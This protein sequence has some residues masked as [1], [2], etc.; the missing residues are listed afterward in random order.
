MTPRDAALGYLAA[1]LSVV[2][3]RAR[4]KRPLLPWREYQARRPTRAE[5][6]SWW[7]RWPDAGVGIVCGTVS[8][9]AV[10][11]FDP[12]NGDGFP[13]LAPRLPL[14]PSV[15]TGGGGVHAY[16]SLPTGERLTKIPG[17]LPGMDLQAEASYV[18]AP[19]S[20]H[21]NGRLYRWRPGLALGEVPLA[22]FPPIIRQLITL[23]R[24]PPEERTTG[25]G[26]LRGDTLT[27]EGV[28]SRL[29]AIRRC[30]LGWVA[31]CP[32]HEDREPSLSIGRGD[33]DQ[34]L[35]FC[36]A[37]CSFAEIL[38]ALAREAA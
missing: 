25:R 1:G 19:P 13:A 31:R 22:P 24:A 27:V 12:R 8:G 36:H 18:I 16:L 35:L 23:H 11:D 37:G 15:E 3:I 7:K 10:L 33:G 17:L 38:A 29:S 28:L 14:T 34:V 9:L 30:G 4:E 32:A 21:P 20:L 5:L 2:P 26:P 6:I